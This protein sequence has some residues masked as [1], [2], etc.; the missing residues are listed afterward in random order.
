MPASPLAQVFPASCEP[1][2]TAARHLRP[3]GLEQD[4]RRVR[5]IA[6]RHRSR[7]DRQAPGKRQGHRHVGRLPTAR[8]QNLRR[9]VWRR[10]QRAGTAQGRRLRADRA[11]SRQDQERADRRLPRL[12][13]DRGA[14][15]AAAAGQGEAHRCRRHH[16]R[17]QV[18]RLRC[19]PYAQAEHPL[20]RSGR[21]ALALR[22]RQSSPRAGDR[23]GA[24]A[25]RRLCRDR[26]FHAASRA[27]VARRALHL[28][29]AACPAK[30]R[31]P[32][33]APL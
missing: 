11:L 27:D 33:C 16:H 20:L 18:G 14:A 2:S 32:I 23:A 13:S 1:R 26:Q 22:H 12:L 29:C 7:R 5:R 4:R 25:R 28:L 19:R 17:C 24:W 6:A 8:S 31:L 10:A 15:R 3:G 9:M 21:G 30:R